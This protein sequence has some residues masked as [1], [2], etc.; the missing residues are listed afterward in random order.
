MFKYIKL[1][2]KMVD[3]NHK[4]IYMVKQVRSLL[5][6]RV[7]VLQAYILKMFYGIVVKIPK[8]PV[9]YEVKFFITVLFKAVAEGCNA[10]NHV[11]GE[12]ISCV[13]GA[14]RKTF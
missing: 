9:G 6:L 4:A 11:F 8:K 12:R 1:V 2:F 13:I 7:R 5:A 10:F 14:V 3:G